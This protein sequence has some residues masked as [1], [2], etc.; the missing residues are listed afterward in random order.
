[1]RIEMTAAKASDILDDLHNL[2]GM[3]G[4]TYD[5]HRALEAIVEDNQSKAPAQPTQLAVYLE[6][7]L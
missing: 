7:P 4:P 3:W 2:D 6:N 5:L 1:M